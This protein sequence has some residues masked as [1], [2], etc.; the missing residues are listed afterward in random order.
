ME[1][2]RGRLLKLRSSQLFLC[3][4]F[5]AVPSHSC[6]LPCPTSRDGVAALVAGRP[7]SETTLFPMESTTR[8]QSYEPWPFLNEPTS[9]AL[10]LPLLL[11]TPDFH[12]T[13]V[14]ATT[15]Q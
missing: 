9:G 15:S 6:A 10:L 1:E 14:K 2:P 5:P 4:N 7:F 12:A 13:D 8:A 3:L 11:P